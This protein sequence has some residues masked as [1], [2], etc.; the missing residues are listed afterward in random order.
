MLIDITKYNI[1]Q[2]EQ[3]KIGQTQ[4]VDIS[5]YS[6]PQY[7]WGEMEEIRLKLENKGE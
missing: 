1:Y 6:N 7:N 5:I 4:G 3:L 2:L